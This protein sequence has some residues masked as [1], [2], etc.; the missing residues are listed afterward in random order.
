MNSD[1]L[2]ELCFACGG[3]GEIRDYTFIKCTHCKG[4][5]IG[6]YKMPFEM[7]CKYCHGVGGEKGVSKIVCKKCNGTG[8]M[9]V[10][11]YALS[12]KL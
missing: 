4:T 12:C 6:I 5:G 9:R 11:L 1:T 3:N 10:E 2:E 8:D 7:I